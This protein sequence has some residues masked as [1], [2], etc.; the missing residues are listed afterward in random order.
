MGGPL[1]KSNFWAD[2]LRSVST[3]LGF[4]SL[5]LL[6]VESL[7]SSLAFAFEPT[8]LF[9]IYTIVVSFGIFI[10]IV[11]LLAMFQPEA[12]AGTRPWH[13]QYAKEFANDVLFAFDGP[14]QNLPNSDRIEAME[15]LADV[16]VNDPVDVGNR[17]YMIFRSDFAS[18][19]RAKAEQAA[20]RSV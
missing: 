19:V 6:V 11:V 7:L 16:I 8:R 1:P 12:L 13:K 5:A 20:R 15:T 3:P 9:L 17:D 10:A 14:L 18:H 4:L 2:I